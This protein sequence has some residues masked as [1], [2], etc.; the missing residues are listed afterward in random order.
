MLS[1]EDSLFQTAFNAA[2]VRYKT[3]ETNLLEKVSAEAR[4]KEIR[5]RIQ[6]VNAEEAEFYQNLKFLLN[7]EQSFVIDKN[8]S[9]KKALELSELNIQKN[10]FLAILRQQIEVSHLQTSFEK[11]KL[12]PDLRIGLTTQSI[13]RNYNQNFVQGGLSIPV[14]AKAQKARIKAYGIN[15]EISK[16]NL[17]VAENQIQT[18]LNNLKLQYQKLQKSLDYYENSALPQADL[19][20]KT[21]LKSFKEGEIEYFEFAQSTTQAWQI[22]EA[23]LVELQNYNQ[24]VINIE[25]LIGNE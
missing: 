9:G 8:L 2:A 21:A 1:E 6:I 13:E 12:K 24:I 4:L 10:P 11:E 16:G 15:E 25:T 5:N 3:G 23:Y 19:I 17:Q 20:L 18:E 22:K 14:F 7:Y